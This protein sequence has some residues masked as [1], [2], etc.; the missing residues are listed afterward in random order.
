MCVQSSGQSVIA[1]RTNPNTSTPH[2]FASTS[3]SLP[4]KLPPKVRICRLFHLLGSGRCSHLC[5]PHC[6]ES[7][8]RIQIAATAS[9]IKM[10]SYVF[11]IFSAAVDAAGLILCFM[12]HKLCFTNIFWQRL[13][14]TS[15]GTYLA[16]PPIRSICLNESIDQ[17]ISKHYPA[18]HPQSV[19]AQSQ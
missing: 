18:N 9:L 17:P 16:R 2:F 15:G 10:P 14:P 5:L 11:Q 4:L 19:L 1:A 8:S 6:E 12:K 13:T 3:L 7:Q